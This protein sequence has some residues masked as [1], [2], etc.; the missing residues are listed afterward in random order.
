MPSTLRTFIG[1]RIPCPPKLLPVLSNLRRLGDA[2]RTAAPDDLHLTFKFLGD[3]PVDQV[4]DIAGQLEAAADG[5]GPLSGRLRGLGAFPG[6]ARPRVIWVGVEFSEELP[7]LAREL[8]DRLAPWGFATEGRTYHP[9]VTLARVQG[10]PPRELA[11]ILQ[12]SAE[13]DFGPADIREIELFQSEP[14]P[15]GSRYTS[16]ARFEFRGE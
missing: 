12:A 16:L 2:L 5:R 10:R 8:D 15:S 7:R 4:G 3:T 6:P 9:H 13:V 11:A 1:V 14:G